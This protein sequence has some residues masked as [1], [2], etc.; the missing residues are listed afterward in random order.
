[1]YVEDDVIDVILEQRRLRDRADR[2]RRERED[3]S[4]NSEMQVETTTTT[5]TTTTALDGNDGQAMPHHPVFG[6]QVAKEAAW[7]TVFCRR[8]SAAVDS[9]LFIAL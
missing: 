3:A 4:M 5:T 1:M 9:S 8:V 7:T 6:A 2:E